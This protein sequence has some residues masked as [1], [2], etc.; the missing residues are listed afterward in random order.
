[1]GKTHSS[2]E[3]S[4]SATKQ[5]LHVNHI[6]SI[7]LHKSKVSAS[8]NAHLAYDS[9]LWRTAY[10]ALHTEV[11]LYQPF[12]GTAS[13]SLRGCWQVGEGH[14]GQVLDRGEKVQI[15]QLIY[16]YI[17]YIYIYLY[18]WWSNAP[19]MFILEP[20]SGIKMNQVR[21]WSPPAWDMMKVDEMSCDIKVR[22]TRT[23]CTPWTRLTRCPVHP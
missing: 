6:N 19:R 4:R 23:R 11:Y 15:I 2:L 5:L 1:M 3:E 13:R 7:V 22:E 14:V 12:E 17:I 18:L 8:H 10:K 20:S 16:I 21:V 9:Y